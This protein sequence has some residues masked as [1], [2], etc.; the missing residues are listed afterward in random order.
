MDFHKIFERSSRQILYLDRPPKLCPKSHKTLKLSMYFYK[1]HFDVF[2]NKM[3]TKRNVS[4]FSSF[5]GSIT[6]E[7]A[8]ALP[9]FL[10]F[11]IQ[12]I[13]ILSLFGLH[14][15]VTM[16]LHQEVASL[17]LQAYA[18]EQ[19]GIDTDSMLMNVLGDIYLKN[20]VIERI[21]K[22]Y[23]DASMIK[24]GSSGIQIQFDKEENMQDVISV[25]LFYRVEPMFGIMGFSGFSMS[26][27]CRMKAWTGYR[28]PIDKESENGEEELVYVTENGS[29]YHK[30]R[31]CT[32]LTLSVREVEKKSLEVLRNEDGGKYYACELCQIG[33]QQS[34]FL[35]DEGNRYH[36]S[37]M[38]SGLKR[39]VYII[40]LSEAGGRRA[41]SRCGGM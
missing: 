6:V 28:Q 9:L 11:C 25:T 34:V 37:L 31:Q 17:S 40:R 20:K 14:S 38:C 16:A 36:T 35:T 12:I 4:L 30:S 3:Y 21:G 10:F 13:S 32:H 33:N 24:G 1:K 8:V 27:R 7:A 41:C 18:Y 2:P 15:A 22:S 23:L 26:N 5:R 29:V 19:A 39:T